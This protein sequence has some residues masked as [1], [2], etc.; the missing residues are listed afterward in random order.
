MDSRHRSQDPAT[1]AGRGQH[2][3]CQ[4]AGC[5]WCSGSSSCLMQG[6]AA[7]TA[8]SA[9]QAS[10]ACLSP[11][12]WHLRGLQEG[13]VDGFFPDGPPISITQLSHHMAL[14]SGQ[15]RT[16]RKRQRQRGICHQKSPCMELTSAMF[17]ETRESPRLASPRSF[18]G[19]APHTFTPLVRRYLRRLCSRFL[20]YGDKRIAYL[21]SQLPHRCRI[22]P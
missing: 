16:N 14:S 19:T 22:R 21:K 8:P 18:R 3:A 1:Q 9:A 12:W 7:T 15:E 6:P 2:S 17:P 11:P 4:A 5:G 10:H 13:R 20:T